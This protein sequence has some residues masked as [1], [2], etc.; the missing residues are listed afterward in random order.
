MKIQNKFRERESAIVIKLCFPS[1]KG[2]LYQFPPVF[3]YSKNFLPKNGH[4]NKN[5]VILLVPL[6]NEQDF[7]D[8][9]CNGR[10]IVQVSSFS[11]MLSISTTLPSYIKQSEAEQE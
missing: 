6:E 3:L 10:S 1:F 5:E 9:Y 7:S 11:Y 2:F 8:G 4:R